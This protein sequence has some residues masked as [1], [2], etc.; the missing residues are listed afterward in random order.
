LVEI[1]VPRPR[2]TLQ[3]DDV[4][5]DFRKL[6][7]YLALPSRGTARIR[8]DVDDELQFHIDMRA[9]ALERQ[10]L[11]AD[12]ARARA[13]RQFGDLD[14]ATRYCTDLDTTAERGRRSMAWLGELRQDAAHALRVF[15]HS[16][17]FTAAT[18][19]T[20][21]LAIG[22]ST[23][24]YG[25]L[26]AYLIRPLPFPEPDRLVWIS[27]APTLHDFPRTPS[28]RDVNWTPVDSLFAATAAYDL[29]GFTIPGDQG[30]ISVTGAWVSLGFFETFGLR[31]AMGRLFRADDYRS[32]TP[33]A[34]ISH[35]LWTRRFA[36]DSGI[37][38]TTITAHSTD[39]PNAA[40]AVTIVGVTPRGFW[41]LHWRESEIL[42]PLPP[43]NWMPTLARLR[44]GASLVDTQRRLDAA[45]R[46]QLTGQ[47]DSA[48]HMALFPALGV[49]SARVRP[50]LVAVFGAALFMLL[51]ACGSVAGALVSR[52]AARRN[53]L[54]LRLALGGSRG[55]VVRQLLTESGVLALFAGALGMA[56]AWGLVALTGPTIE[57][58]LGTTAPGGAAALRPGVEILVLS[59]VASV[60]AGV[61][62]GLIPALTFLRFDRIPAT[63]TSLA[64]RRGGSARSGGARIRQVVIAGQVAV[65]MILLFG[66]G[67]MFR[68]IAHIAG[69]EL[70]FRTDGVVVASMLLPDATYPDSAS[71]RRVMDRLLDRVARTEGVRSVAAASPLPFWPAGRFVVLAEG[72]L[73][74]SSAAPRAGVY[75]VSP[76]Y[77]QTM[78]V[79][80]RAGRTFRGTDDHT[81]PLVVVISEDLARRLLPDAAVIGR[82]IRVR[83]PHLASFDDRDGFP[84]RTVVGIVGDTKKS[85]APNGEPDAPDV[86]VPYAQNP[87][88]R[89]SI[90]VRTDGSEGAIVEPVRRAVGTIDPA[91]ALSGIES[92]TELVAEETSQRRGLTTL[93]G[94]FAVFALG[95]SA[96][97]LYASLSYAVVQRRSELAIRMAV[98]AS[99]PSILRLVVS[100]AVVTAGVGVVIGAAASLALG[101]VLAS[102][103]YGVG[104]TDPT[105]LIAISLL[106]TIAAVGACAVPGLRATRTDP[107]LAL[108]E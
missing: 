26:H 43:E 63:F 52:T 34:I 21:A 13:L 6:R 44:R 81:A 39:R 46:A 85:F 17:A 93:L 60:L 20:L 71:R 57:R 27:G 40:R 33:V 88:A 48:W 68:T 41:P 47:V 100:E 24:A 5:T 64:V 10:G 61:A 35:E 104:T 83:V 51:A 106:L 59:L 31:A 73:V 77:F 103:L 75:T 19:L 30:A 11:S 67:L 45:V 79:R 14:D 23:A 36:G 98:G 95:L 9:E 108:R 16:S 25:V 90:V 29:D 105:T 91:I 1:H 4:M 50:V 89:Q 58:Q 12:E 78:D 54:A 70:G 8:R 74:D 69:T 102:Q 7:R 86:Y 87:R 32:D 3:P 94:A 92:M 28:L 42:R 37:I 15:R 55:R 80:L 97:A 96:L 62:L 2:A 65:T 38:G 56:I 99:A 82:R 22:A 49:H 84:W 66:A 101:R 76:A 18:V 53:E 107:A 72:S